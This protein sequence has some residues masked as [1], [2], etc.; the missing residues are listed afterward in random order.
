MHAHAQAASLTSR[1]AHNM[2]MILEFISLVMTGSWY[3]AADLSDAAQ[4]LSALVPQ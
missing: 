4:A 3:E 2:L 1:L